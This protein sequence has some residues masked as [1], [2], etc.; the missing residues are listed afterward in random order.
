VAALLI[1]LLA[2]AVQGLVGFGSGLVS[3]PLLTLFISP[4]TVV[5]LTLVHGLA[6]NMYLSVR[7]RKNIQRKRVL[8]LFLSGIAGIPIGAL[9]LLFLP[10]SALRVMIG[11]VIIVF[12]M[13]LLLGFSRKMGREKTAL[14]PIGLVSGILNGS[15]SMSGPPVILF[16]SNQGVGKAYFRANL[17]TYFFL[18]NVV[19]LIVFLITGIL[20]REAL[21]MAMILIPPL[22]AGIILGELLSH[23]VSESL[24]RKI[25]LFL[26]TGAGLAAL[27]T[28]LMAIL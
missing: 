11:I 7:N 5:P 6:M 21:L 14:V 9:I 18:L 2:G 25:A 8:P 28:G 10:S 12:S 1:V 17:V 16:L 22:P 26:V 15:I 19:T 24:F 4:R 13:L 23:K 20:D 27:V 3:V